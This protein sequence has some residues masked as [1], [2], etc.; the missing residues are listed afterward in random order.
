MKVMNAQQKNALISQQGDRIY[1]RIRQTDVTLS[2]AALPTRQNTAVHVDLLTH[3][4]DGN[5]S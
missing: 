5:W 1:I 4:F 3:K 2:V